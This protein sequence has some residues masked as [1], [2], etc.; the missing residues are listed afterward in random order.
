[1]VPSPDKQ[2]PAQ[3]GRKAWHAALQILVLPAFLLI[4]EFVLEKRNVLPAWGWPEWKVYLTGEGWSL[5]FWINL[6][7]WGAWLA[8][9]TDPRR[10]FL[11][12]AT[13]LFGAWQFFAYFTT[14]KYLK[15]MYHLPNVHILQFTIY[16]WRNAWVLAK[17]FLHWWHLAAALLCLAV[18]AVWLGKCLEAL[19]PWMSSLRPWKRRVSL[20]IL[21]LC[22]A[23]LSVTTLGW[24][25]FQDPLPWDANWNRMFWQYGVMLQGNTTNLQV[26]NRVK[27]PHHEGRPRYNVLVILNESLR[28]DAVFPTVRMLDGF[29]DTL[30]PKVL[31]RVAADSQYY[32][33]TEARSNSG[34]TN[35]SV[36][37][38]A[39]GLPPEA[40]TYDFHRY[41]TLWNFGKSMGYRTFVFT[42]QDWRWEHFD[43]F[44]LDRDVDQAV[45]RRDFAAPLANDLGVDDGLVVDSL[46]HYLA[47]HRGEPFFGMI[48]FNVTHPPFYGG[49]ASVNLPPYT[50]ER[51]RVS[52][53]LLDEYTDRLLAGLEKLGLYD[54]TFIVY[55]SDHG[56]NIRS[57]NLSRQ[58][59]FYDDALRVPFWIKPPRDSAWAQG[60]A[61]AARN[62]RA[63]GGRPVENLDILP[64]VLDFLRLPLRGPGGDYAGRSLLGSGSDSVRIMS[65]QNTC[66]IRSWSPEGCFVLRQP[67]KLVLAN[68]TPPQLFDLGR[69]PLEQNNLWTVDSVRKANDPWLARYMQAMRGREDLCRRLKRNCPEEFLT[70]FGGP[71]L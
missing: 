58:G 39:T 69:D 34:S 43:E 15:D 38:L 22:L 68:H 32:L 17:D 3:A 27:L 7:A 36:P 62:L 48:Q 61:D 31:R 71:H 5:L 50:Q 63:W 57:R 53:K 9:K 10:P 6:T 70:S 28:A 12:A 54:S 42:S 44:F 41:Q 19:A 11:L 2:G 65:A 14:Y 33:F 37:S 24:H 21:S 64:T 67:M 29:H 60:R 40:T 52:V 1:L 8:W 30:S 66:E 35:V 47:G 49:P 13:A 16:E 46:L 55:T 18:F 4:L 25:R 51:F 20:G 23:A 56:E 59:C 45:H 26:G